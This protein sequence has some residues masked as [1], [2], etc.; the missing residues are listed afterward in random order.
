MRWKCTNKSILHCNIQLLI[1]KHK[2]HIVRK[3]RCS[4]FWVSYLCCSCSTKFNI[5][6]SC[7]SSI[8]WRVT[9]TSYCQSKKKGRF[10][11]LCWLFFWFFFPKIVI[12]SSKKS[13]RSH[14]LCLPFPVVGPQSIG[15]E[16]HHGMVE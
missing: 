13:D 15:Q 9:I 5:L 1:S 4:K 6:W 7:L 11:F 8:G 16:L 2:L 10:Y 12:W 14:D 3:S